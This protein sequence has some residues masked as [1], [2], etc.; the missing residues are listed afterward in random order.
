MPVSYNP[1]PYPNPTPY[2]SPSQGGNPYVTPGTIGTSIPANWT[3]TP[4][5]LPGGAPSAGMQAW[6]S[7]AV[8][9]TGG[10]TLY[11]APTNQTSGSVAGQ[12]TSNQSQ[13]SQP[14]NTGGDTG[15]GSQTKIT[16]LDDYMTDQS[17]TRKTYRSAMAEGLID[18]YGNFINSGG[19]MNIPSGP[20][21]AELNAAY[22]PIFA[23]LNQAE[24]QLGGLYNTQMGLI[25]QQGANRVNELQ[26][27]RDKSL[28]TLGK[29]RSDAMQRKEDVL[30]SSRRLYNELGMA[31][32]QRFG[33]ATSAG[34]AA[35]ELQN[36]EFQRSNAMNNRAFEE[37]VREIGNRE[38]EVGSQYT[39]GQSRIREQMDQLKAQAQADFQ[40]NLLEISRER[41]S[42]E[43]EKA[44]RKLTSLEQYRQNL[45]SVAVAERQAQQ[46]LDMWKQQQDYSLQV[47]KQ[48]LAA[49]NSAGSGAVNSYFNAT[50]T[51]PTTQYAPGAVG[52]QQAQ[53]MTGYRT[54]D[55][56][57]GFAPGIY[58][59]EGNQIGSSMGTYQY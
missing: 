29:Q 55:D 43:A 9:S 24:G 23:Y 3:P 52:R 10:G 36:I 30:T 47:Y 57:Q 39:L 19:G 22:D 11:Q 21:D 59:R 49:Q 14:T 35:S 6:N 17:G 58:D 38:M 42:T 13:Q 50:T 53:T 7:G 40:N 32:R 44:S 48:Q 18:E 15:G 12:T 46:Q 34:Q 20:T 51:S 37:T 25:D 56:L 16:N 31:N 54:K 8:T 27:E 28:N 41:A 45:L 1:V 26:A 2:Q 5:Y 4:Y 33:G